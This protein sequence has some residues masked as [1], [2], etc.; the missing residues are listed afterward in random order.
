MIWFKAIVLKSRSVDL[1]NS[2]YLTV[3]YPGIFQLGFNWIKTDLINLSHA[4]TIAAA[5]KNSASKFHLTDIQRWNLFFWLIARFFFIQMNILELFGNL[6]RILMSTFML[7]TLNLTL[8][9]WMKSLS[10]ERIT[11]VC[12]ASPSQQSLTYTEKKQINVRRERERK[13][14][15]WLCMSTKVGK[16]CRVGVALTWPCEAKRLYAFFCD[17][18]QKVELGALQ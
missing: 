15:F 7:P 6:T 11:D 2:T 5:E 13:E 18:A 10:D 17:G 1:S 14:M 9:S 3:S 16:A 4:R 8:H 12:D